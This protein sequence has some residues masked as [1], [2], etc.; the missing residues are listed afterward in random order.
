MSRSMS[1]YTP[2]FPNGS[3]FTF[4]AGSLNFAFVSATTN[5]QNSAPAFPAGISKVASVMQKPSNPPQVPEIRPIRDGH[6]EDGRITLTAKQSQICA[7][8]LAGWRARRVFRSPVLIV[9]CCCVEGHE[10]AGQE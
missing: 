2:G 3:G 10:A 9:S 4:T 8:E 7:Q 1:C 5:D 6:G